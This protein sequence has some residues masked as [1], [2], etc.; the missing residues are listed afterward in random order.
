MSKKQDRRIRRTKER[1]RQALLELILEKP[2]D[3]ITVQNILDKGDVSRSAFYAHY[4]HKD[5]LLRQGMPE[6]I[7][8]YGLND[9]EG[10]LPNVAGL[11]AHIL[12]GKQWF[13]AMQGNAGMMLTNQLARQR[14][15]ENWVAVLAPHQASASP[16][17]QAT[18]HYLT[19]A[20]MSLLLWWSNDGMQQPPETMNEWFQEMAVNGVVSH[21]AIPKNNTIS[22]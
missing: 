6:D 13:E 18:A 22:P 21:K 20:L 7:L 16:P 8:S 15:V 4:S 2:Y 11:F 19:G 1:L 14:M 3:E 10:V 5:D 17:V 12:A 9:S